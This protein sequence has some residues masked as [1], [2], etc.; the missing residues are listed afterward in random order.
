MVSIFILLMCDISFFIV[1]PENS[2]YWYLFHDLNFEKDGVTYYSYKWIIISGVIL[3]S[4]LTYAAEK[5]I[6]DNI[7]NKVD[8]KNEERDMV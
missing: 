5:L 7:T 6:I 8:K 1:P 2:V 4:I 3:N